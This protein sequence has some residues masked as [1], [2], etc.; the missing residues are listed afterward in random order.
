MLWYPLTFE[1][2]DNGTF[3]I[4][5]GSPNK[6]YKLLGVALNPKTFAPVSVEVEY[7]PKGARKT[8]TIPVN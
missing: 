8:K 3:A 4:P 6:S 1:I 5:Q 7:G 2:E